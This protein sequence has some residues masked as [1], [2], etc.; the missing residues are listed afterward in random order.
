MSKVTWA[1]EK[2]RHWGQPVPGRLQHGRQ[3]RAQQIYGCR[4]EFCEVQPRM[5]GD[6]PLSRSERGRRLRLAKRGKPVPLTVKH[7]AYAY[8]TYGC[9]CDICRQGKRRASR[10]RLQPRP[11]TGHWAHGHRDG[12]DTDVIHWPPRGTGTWTCP[13]CG[14]DLERRPLPLQEAA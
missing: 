10:K 5:V 14:L 4:C 12:F 8:T 3:T 7:G 11:T 6:V 9:R 1:E 13:D 2:A